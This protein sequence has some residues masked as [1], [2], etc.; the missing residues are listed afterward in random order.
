MDNK[1]EW[2]GGKY[3]QGVQAITLRNWNAFLRYISDRLL[4]RTTYI[5]RG[6]NNINWKLEPALDRKSLTTKQRAAH[7]QNFK[8]AT[9]GRRGTH[10]PGITNE[11]DWWALGQHHGLATPLLD[12]TESP[13]VAL[14]FAML[15]SSRTKTQEKC[16]V[17]ALSENFVKRTSKNIARTNRSSTD[18]KPTVEVIRSFSD[19]NDRLVNQRGLFTRGPD[20]VDLQAWVQK[21]HAPTARQLRRLIKFIVPT[22]N[23]NNCLRFLNRM[24]ISHSTL[25]PDLTGAS[26]FCNMHLDIENY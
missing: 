14:Y 1:Q 4:E 3:D 21:Y 9:R 10:P 16:C 11:N 25:F 8:F 7:L 15:A 20:N 6:H 19:E 26:H 24:N 18:R 17:W 22:N 23:A 12:W 2:S 5:Y 13:F